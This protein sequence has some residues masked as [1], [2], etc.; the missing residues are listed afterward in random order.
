M[1]NVKKVNQKGRLEQSEKI[2]KKQ[3][4]KTKKYIFFVYISGQGTNPIVYF[5]LVPN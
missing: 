1:P 4:N 3:I 2:K 5:M